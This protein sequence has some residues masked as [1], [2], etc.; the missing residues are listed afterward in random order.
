MIGHP[1]NPLSFFFSESS[2]FPRSFL[3][4]GSFLFPECFLFPGSFLQQQAPC[5]FLLE[6]VLEKSVPLLSLPQLFL[7]DPARGFRVLCPLFCFFH[8]RGRISLRFLYFYGCF[9]LCRSQALLCLLYPALHFAL[10]TADPH[11]GIC[12]GLFQVFLQPGFLHAVLVESPGHDRAPVLFLH[13]L[14]FDPGDLLL[15]FFPGFL[16]RSG[17]LALPACRG[18]S[19]LTQ[20][21]AKLVLTGTA[22]LHGAVYA[23]LCILLLFF[24][25]KIKQEQ[26]R[27]ALRTF[28]FS[29]CQLQPQ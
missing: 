22:H 15:I 14:P 11:G 6:L 1:R 29:G 18:L 7:Q 16:C 27:G 3:S 12:P 21:F 19:G 26:P 8:F 5:F 2:L 24:P 23:V 9:F 4:S 17:K 20:F 10:Q 28:Y 25:V 13:E